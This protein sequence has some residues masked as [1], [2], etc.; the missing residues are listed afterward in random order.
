MA[1][2]Q[3][4][5]SALGIGAGAGVVAL[6]V[7]LLGGTDVVLVVCTGQCITGDVR[8]CIGGNFQT[9]N[10]LGAV[11]AVS[12]AR[13]KTVAEGQLC[14]IGILP[15]Y[16]DAAQG[17]QAVAIVGAVGDSTVKITH[18]NSS[19]LLKTLW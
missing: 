16:L 13:G 15:L 7:Y 18:N 4:E 6:D 12:V 3:T 1:V 9:A 11:A 2:V 10:V 14:L 5:S 8:L 19:F 17:A